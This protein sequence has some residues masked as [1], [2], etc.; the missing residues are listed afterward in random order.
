MG[1]MIWNLY[2]GKAGDFYFLQNIQTGSG[3]Y[4]A[5]YS[6]AAGVISWG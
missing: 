5:T 1:W 4:S 6:M 3:V 2:S